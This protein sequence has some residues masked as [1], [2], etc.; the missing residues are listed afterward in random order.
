MAKRNKKYIITFL[1][2]VLFI[3]PFFSKATGLG[4]KI[5]TSIVQFIF[6]GIFHITGIIAGAM[7]IVLNS[8]INMAVRTPAFF[9]DPA[10]LVVIGWGVCRDIANLGFVFLLIFIGIATILQLQTY[11]YKKLLVG[12][13]IAAL[14]VNFSMTI[15][16][17]VID[18][19]N[20]VAMEFLCKATES[21]RDPCNSRYLSEAISTGI[22]FSTVT[23]TTDNESLMKHLKL[24]QV[25][26]VYLLGSVI[27]LIVSFILGALAFLFVI[28]L[29][30]LMILVI[31]SPLA[32]VAMA[33][34]SSLGTKWWGMLLNQSFFAPIALF[35]LYLI[36][37][38]FGTGF[39]GFANPGGEGFFDL[40]STPSIE[41]SGI[42]VQFVIASVLLMASLVVSKKMGAYGAAGVIN[43]GKKLSKSAKGYAG[44]VSARAT[45]KATG[46]IAQ[47]MADS[48][49]MQHLAA[50]PIAGKA[51]RPLIMGLN[52]LGAEK[53]KGD[54]AKIKSYLNMSPGSLASTVATLSPGM[55][56]QVFAKAG[57]EQMEKTVAKMD[58]AAQ[59]KTG[60]SIKDDR[61]R[62]KFARATKN[63]EV[64]AKI[65][66]GT[67]VVNK[68][69][70][71]EY[72]ETLKGGDLNKL[73][74]ENL[75]KNT[76]VM[77]GFLS[78]AHSSDIGNAMK[79]R[80]N[81]QNMSKS[82]NNY[83]SSTKRTSR[84]MAKAAYE[85][86]NENLGKYFENTPGKQL[87]ES[88]DKVIIK[89]SKEEK[90][91]KKKEEDETKK[92]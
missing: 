81:I 58:E 2:L 46:G 4:E 60:R 47:K 21:S 53:Q 37:Y 56:E 16:L 84:E 85:L 9:T 57:D 29:I 59:I 52:K 88:P 54:D 3:T 61:T 12:I 14:F 11:S 80:E 72:Y 17:M 55:R 64:G 62:N 36:T 26:M 7:G 19:S 45:V 39:K 25:I 13:I 50:I 89:K 48:K 73:N 71:G 32:F 20:V 28:R 44:K 6:G 10:G 42:V 1:A 75:D 8:A 67:D 91:E 49:A 82:L 90:K 27:M 86:G 30:V 41:S 79:S 66:H 43:Q 83:L 23:A 65:H 31:F 33:L 69:Q 51:T 34:K 38:W 74:Y 78:K 76:A 24:G 68:E 22:G 40:V 35:F 63:L 5:V 18:A 70:V 92:T 77:E 87:V 15:T